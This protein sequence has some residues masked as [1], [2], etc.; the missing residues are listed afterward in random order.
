[1]RSIYI[2][3]LLSFFATY[4]FAQE[5]YPLSNEMNFENL[6]KR[7]VGINY[8]PLMHGN[9]SIPC[10]NV[11]ICDKVIQKYS[12]LTAQQYCNKFQSDYFR[13]LSKN[14]IDEISTAAIDMNLANVLL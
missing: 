1:M 10:P 14:D 5:V 3:L 8:E 12:G 4:S 7:S 6:S 2:I 9:L 13:F 11:T